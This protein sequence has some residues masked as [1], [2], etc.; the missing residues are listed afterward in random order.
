LKTRASKKTSQR[1]GPA[2]SL[3]SPSGAGGSRS[4][5]VAF[6]LAALTVAAYLPAMQCGFIWDDDDDYIQNNTTLRSLDGL[7]RIWFEIGATQ[8]YYPLVHTSYWLEYRLWALSPA[9][10]HAVNVLLHALGVVLLWRVLK[11]LEVPGAWLAAAVFGLHPVQVESVAWITER[12]NVLSGVFYFWSGLLYLGYALGPADRKGGPGR[13]RPYAASLVLFVL[14]LFS[15]TV[16]GS[17]PFALLLV[18]WWKRGRVTWRD[19]LA[20]LP[21]IAAGIGLG[22]LTAWMERH[23]VGA[24]GAEWDLSALE[25]GLVAGRALCFYVSKLFC[26]AGLTFIYPRWEIDA[27]KWVQYLYPAAAVAAILV[28]WKLRSRVGRGP[29]TAVLFFAGTLFPALGF[30]NLYPMRYSYVADHFQYLACVGVIA[31]VVGTGS[32]AAGRLAGGPRAALATLPVL[33]VGLLGTATWVREQAYRDLE[34]L[35]R[36][37]LDKNP[38]AWIAHNNLGAILQERG[39]LD[40]AL[41]HYLQAVRLKG[42]YALALGNV[43][44]IYH[45]RG[46][47]E[48]EIKYYRRALGFD[49]LLVDTRNRLGAAYQSLGLSDEAANQFLEGIRTKP[50]FAS[51]YYNLANVRVSQGRL[52]QAVARYL[53]ALHSRPDYAEAHNNLGM[54][55]LR[56]GRVAQALAHFQEASILKPEWIGPMVSAARLLAVY[57]DSEFHDQAAAIRLAERASELTVHRDPWV[58]DT[59]AAA[60]ASAGQFEQATATAQKALGFALSGGA[61]DLAREIRERL[62]LYRQGRPFRETMP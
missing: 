29:L 54:T 23:R 51:S 19:L 14:A 20:L 47:P 36:N 1:R 7:R 43:G 37:T 9:G 41:T 32:R 45:L 35:W 12:K 26:P 16:T 60:Y 3:E 8:Q 10:Y 6:L 27:G 39:E 42:D 25:R 18:I 49:P 48:Q 22:L 55:L 2:L 40:Q 28:L 62:K 17:L 13:W 4:L 57:P 58:L 38:N 21:F 61:A 56:Q 31:L 34:T 30:F 53:E 52:D 24:V 50:D 11:F 44:I 59:L 33:L 15:K 46:E 5:A